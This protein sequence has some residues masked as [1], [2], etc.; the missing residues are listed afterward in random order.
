MLEQVTEI[1]RLLDLRESGADTFLGDQP[2]DPP[3][4]VFGGQVLAQALRAACRT[5]P[6]E[7]LPHS[8]HGYFIAAGRST[9]PIEYAVLRLRDGRSVSTRRVTA[10][11]AG[12]VIFEMMVS[13][14]PGADPVDQ[15][16]IPWATSAEHL[17]PLEV[18]L[19]SFEG[20]LDGWWVRPRAFDLRYLGPHPREAVELPAE[21]VGSTARLW[22]R[23]KDPVGT[24]PVVWACLTAYMSDMTLLDPVLLAGR[25][26]TL[27]PGS[28]ASLDHAM[29][30]HRIPDPSTW[31][32]YER[33]LEAMSNRRGLAAGR[34]FDAEG[35]CCTVAQEGHLSQAPSPALGRFAA[36]SL[37]AVLR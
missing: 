17:L 28:I 11:Q 24:D 22:A 26:T 35:L 30:F 33:E 13:L 23:T 15:R 27:G 31:L 9:E 3:A 14:A 12:A 8:L 2:S 29:W 1:L 5:V 6:P 25:R 16:P 19:R 32:L 34:I 37:P 36:E 18:R 10:T 21:R 4:R 20:E 7:R